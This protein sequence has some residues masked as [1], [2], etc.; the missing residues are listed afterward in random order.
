M[1]QVPWTLSGNRSLHLDD[2]VVSDQRAE[3][4][5]T[6]LWP[7]EE[8]HGR[9]LLFAPPSCDTQAESAAKRSHITPVDEEESGDEPTGGMEQGLEIAAD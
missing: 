2:L 8:Y 9:P 5:R 4:I 1:T 6:V 7:E 3:I